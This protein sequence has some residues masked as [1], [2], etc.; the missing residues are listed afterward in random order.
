ML[1]LDIEG[2]ELQLKINQFREDLPGKPEYENWCYMDITVMRNGVSIYHD[3]KNTTLLTCDEVKEI[4]N[5]IAGI[6]DGSITQDKQLSF[7]E[8]DIE[9]E[10]VFDDGKFSWADMILSYWETGGVLTANRLVLCLGRD[11]LERLL[12]YLQFKTYANYDEKLFEKCCKEGVIK[13]IPDK[14]SF[15]IIDGDIAPGEIPRY[16]GVVGVF[17]NDCEILDIVAGL[18]NKN[19]ENGAMRYIHQTANEL[20]RNLASD[21]LSDWQ[22]ENG[23]EVLSCTCGIIEDSSPTV[24]IEKDESYVYWK[25]LGHNQ[26]DNEDYYYPLNYIFDKKQYEQAL[27]ELKEFAEDSNIY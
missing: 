11:K 24:F 13:I 21:K 12:C 6:L 19:W 25:A 5:T 17:I 9:F 26:I 27:Q 8:P 3:R 7:I 10:F 20:Y 4:R 14:L 23:I 1:F 22:E 2:I 16:R 15:K 18:E